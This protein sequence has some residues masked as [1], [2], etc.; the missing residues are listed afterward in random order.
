MLEMM[1][2]QSRSGWIQLIFVILIAAFVLTFYSG[3]KLAGQLAGEAPKPML[4]VAGTT[5]DSAE[6]DLAMK[7]SPDAPG[8]GASGFEKMQLQ[9]RYEKLRLPYSGG[10]TEMA[11]LTTPQ[12]PI[13]AI[14]LQKVANELIEA[15]LVEAE[16]KKLGLSVSDAEL[17]RR[18]MQ[19]E[20]VFGISFRD[21]N[22][23]F[24]PKKYD[25]FV[26]FSL[27]S[28]K[29]MLESLLR[30][31]ILR[32]K[33]AQIVVGGIQLTPAELDAL[34]AS[35]AKRTH[36]EFVALDAETI[37]GALTVTDADADA[38]A[39]AHE[40]DI[41]A[42]YEAK[43][44]TYKVPDRWSVHGILI[45]APSK[46]GLPDDKKA[47][48]DGQWAEKKKAAEAVKAELDKA[49]NGE[50]PLDAPAEGDAPPAGE[51]KKATELQGEEKAKRLA[52][53]F[54]KT[55]ATKSEHDMTKDSGGFFDD[56]SADGLSHSPFGADVAKAVSAAEPGTLVG[57]VEA[58]NGW[59]V[60]S[61]DKKI[62]GKTT[63][64]DAAVKRTLAM[65]L[66]RTERAAAELDKVAQSVLA[67][68]EATP[69]TALA[70]VIKKWN[71]AHGGKEDGPLHA[72]DTPA[73]GKSPLEALNG[74]MEAMLGLPP[75]S[76]D[77]NDIPGMGKMPEVAAAAAKL[78]A[79]APVAKQVFKSEDG[80][81]RYVVRRGNDSVKQT[82]EAD[83][84]IKDSLGRMLTQARR[85]EAWHGY[86][87]KLQVAADAGKQIVQTQEFKDAVGREK[88]R[89][90]TA[91]KRAAASEDEG[92]EEGGPKGMKVEIGG[93][94]VKVE[95]APAK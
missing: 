62:A 58:P 87:K 80:K 28:T 78:K 20:R 82:P 23:Q 73:L 30:R 75:K 74:G 89:Y 15:V 1:R 27:S 44:D 9:Q 92:D 39:A 72:A 63:P 4:E 77:P 57:P 46:E 14:K 11:Q 64:L 35:D 59:W 24:D 18:V 95:T 45:A 41:A 86:V 7:L 8:P 84:K 31:E 81:T 42:A 88:A 56:K 71:L 53:F 37:A 85:V 68:A 90:E 29:A 21:E 6:L 65:D 36:L 26:R 54:A 51:A 2:R 22:G 55:A 94:P 91:A 16:A 10:G 79:D 93:K 32:D 25:Q 49:W 52:A 33:M 40:K 12:D 3:S 76:D 43:A 70:D 69:T 5:I 34:V 67:A 50:T 38:W 60:L 48:V 66:V 13:P 61:V 17:S 19:L 83:A 47:E